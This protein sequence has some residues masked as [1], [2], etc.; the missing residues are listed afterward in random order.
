METTTSLLTLVSLR[1]AWLRNGRTERSAAAFRQSLDQDEQRRN[2]EYGNGCSGRHSTDYGSTHDLSGHGAGAGRNPERHAPENER[3]RGHQNRA[4]T[5]PCS[6]ERGINQ[7]FPLFVFLLGEK[8]KPLIDA[9]I[10]KT[11]NRDNPKI[12]QAGTPCRAFCS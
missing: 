7:R 4:Q 8:G 6:F 12:A 3:K 11:N 5:K 10:R 1:W 2:D 9:R